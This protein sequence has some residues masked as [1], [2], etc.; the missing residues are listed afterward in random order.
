MNDF[1]ICFKL[2]CILEIY[3]A[4]YVVKFA[5]ILQ[6]EFKK[7]TGYRMRQ[8]KQRDVAKEN[9][10]YLQLMQQ[11]LPADTTA[12][13]EIASDQQQENTPNV[14]STSSI[15][16]NHSNVSS[17]TQQQQQNNSRQSHEKNGH[18]VN[19]VGAL[20]NGVGHTSKSH[21]KSLEKSKEHAEHDHRYVIINKR[22]KIVLIKR[23]PLILDQK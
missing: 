16:H 18:M 8:R 23:T 7:I 12:T 21:R 19:G 5:V 13:T 11:A 1:R 4:H 14:V 2:N 9:E 3:F 20:T 10:F 22:K 6:C 17:K 15:I